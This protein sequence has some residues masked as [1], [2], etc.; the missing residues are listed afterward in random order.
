[1]VKIRLLIDYIVFGTQ[2]LQQVLSGFCSHCFALYFSE[3]QPNP[4]LPASEFLCPRYFLCFWSKFCPP[5]RQVVSA[6]KLTSARKKTS[7]NYWQSRFI[8]NPAPSPSSVLTLCPMSYTGSQNFPSRIFQ[9]PTMVVGLT[10]NNLLVAFPS[11]T[12][13]TIIFWCFLILLK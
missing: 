10:M 11:L 1:M 7:T 12:H 13:F 4:Q 3:Q 8:Q 6:R 9:L 5:L 2:M